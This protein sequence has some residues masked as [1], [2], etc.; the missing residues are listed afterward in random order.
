M[1]TVI[2]AAKVPRPI[3]LS[4]DMLDE[5]KVLYVVQAYAAAMQNYSPRTLEE[6]AGTRW[7]GPGGRRF[8][9]NWRERWPA[10]FD[11]A[12]NRELV[13][14]DLAFLHKWKF[15][16][17]ALNAAE[18]L[19][20]KGLRPVEWAAWNFDYGKSIGSRLPYFNMVFSAKR[21]R[22][23]SGWCRTDQP[24]L[25]GRSMPGP[26]YKELMQR[27][28]QME[29]ALR[30]STGPVAEVVE[31]YFPPGYYDQLV[32]EAQRETKERLADLQT[33]FRDGEWIW[34]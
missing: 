15:Y 5:V 25:G 16:K 14:D 7:I 23:K 29:T 34:R 27:Y 28:G 2:Y 26:K 31:R 4:E 12:N 9:Q 19:T 13:V 8:G 11:V 30:R 32:A 20:E 3:E 17:T 22:S 18:A 21:I 6:P 1:S 10:E 33:R 24:Q